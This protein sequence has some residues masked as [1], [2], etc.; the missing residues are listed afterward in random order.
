MLLIISGL[1]ILAGFILISMQL[2]YYYK[3]KANERNLIYLGVF[4]I[5]LGL[6]KIADLR[7]AT[8][9]LNVNPKMLFY[10]AI[11]YIDGVALHLTHP[12]RIQYHPFNPT[13]L[14][15]LDSPCLPFCP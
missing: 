13:C 6:F 2:S 9:I 3:H 11:A 15:A 1:C 14:P 8:M 7:M 4:S 12:Q 10:I 5:M